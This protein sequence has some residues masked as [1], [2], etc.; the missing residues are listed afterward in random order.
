VLHDGVP[1][2]RPFY[3]TPA[4][5]A[6]DRKHA[7]AT[8]KII[9]AKFVVRRFLK[10]SLAGFKLKLAAKAARALFLKRR[11]SNITLRK[12][13]A[14]KYR[15]AMTPVG[16]NTTWLYN[17]YM[18]TRFGQK[19]FSEVRGLMVE[20]GLFEEAI[21]ARHLKKP[22]E[23]IGSC[24]KK[25][26][27]CNLRMIEIYRKQDDKDL[28]WRLLA[29]A[30]VILLSSGL[31]KVIR[32]YKYIF[33]AE[34]VAFVAVTLCMTL[35]KLGLQRFWGVS[36]YL[37]FMSLGSEFKPSQFVNTY[38]STLR[39]QK[40]NYF[41]GSEY[42]ETIKRWTRQRYIN[43]AFA[44][45]LPD[46]PAVNTSNNSLRVIEDEYPLDNF[47]ADSQRAELEASFMH[48]ASLYVNQSLEL[49][50]LEQLACT[51]Q[52]TADGVTQAYFLRR[53]WRKAAG[54]SSHAGFSLP[55][56]EKSHQI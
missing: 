15:S 42:N 47:G 56:P 21:V 18:K 6:S 54:I 17:E 7:A 49:K 16:P 19:L 43:Q 12:T 3:R 26:I 39:G 28:F 41:F 40:K 44:F 51:S 34:L 1:N 24:I 8:L 53:V 36:K 35:W 22:A 45:L 2:E 23:I 48:N 13:L 25:H 37:R 11:V 38:D 10:Q 52:Q 20:A 29:V 32:V 14:R 27:R 5:R 4:Q 55:G 9:A 33:E 50:T 31:V 46:R 30:I